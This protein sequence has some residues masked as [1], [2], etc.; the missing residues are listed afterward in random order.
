MGELADVLS[1]Q[2][3]KSASTSPRARSPDVDDNKTDV[4]CSSSQPSAG[5]DE[6]SARQDQDLGTEPLVSQVVLLSSSKSTSPLC[7]LR[8]CKN[9]CLTYT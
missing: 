2:P 8:L 1:S 9:S 7:Y 6:S 4:Q 3:D 5:V